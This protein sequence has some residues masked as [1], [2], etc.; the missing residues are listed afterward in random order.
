MIPMMCLTMKRSMKAIAFAS[1][2]LV[3]ND[4]LRALVAFCVVLRMWMLQLMLVKLLRCLCALALVD[5]HY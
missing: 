2:D 4:L 5:H 1:V 3:E